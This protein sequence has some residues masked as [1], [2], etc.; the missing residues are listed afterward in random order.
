MTAQAHLLAR[1][2]EADPEERFVGR[3]ERDERRLREVHLPRDREH[4]FA[5]E[6]IR[7]GDDARRIAAEGI[8]REHVD[9]LHHDVL[10]GVSPSSVSIAKS[11]RSGAKSTVLARCPSPF[12]PATRSSLI[13][14]THCNNSM[15]YLLSVMACSS[16]AADRDLSSLCGIA[17][18]NPIPDI[19]RR[20]RGGAGDTESTAASRSGRAPPAGRIRHDDAGSG[21]TMALVQMSMGELLANLQTKFGK[22]FSNYRLSCHPAQGG[23]QDVDPEARHPR[24]LHDLPHGA[25]RGRSS[26]SSIPS[27]FMSPN[28]SGTPTCSTPSRRISCRRSFRGSCIRRR[29]RSASGAPAAR[30]A[31]RRTASPFSSCGTFGRN[32]IDLALEVYGTDVSK[33]ACAIAREGVYAARKVENV[34]GDVRRKYFEAKGPEY[35]V[36]PDVRRCVKFSVHDLFSP[37]PF[38]LLDLV[39]C[40]NV[41]IHFDHAVRNDVLRAISRG[42][43]RS[44]AAHS[45]QERGRHGIGSRTVTNSSIRGTRSTGKSSSAT[46]EGGRR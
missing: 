30:R 43:R 6:R 33:E 28:S 9:L 18:A 17:I 46:P 26:S 42:P 14:V 39:V 7:L 16:R 35:R 45:R 12:P 32:G 5:R 36:A 24:R 1:R 40:R 2:E 10:H 38:S 22:D 23:A 21:V 20:R 3:G 4:H 34:P 37:S 15:M 25:I 27:R 8:R 11:E 29:G 31:R 44:R 13:R 41:L 19:G